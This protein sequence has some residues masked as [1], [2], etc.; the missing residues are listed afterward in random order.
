[1]LQSRVEDATIEIYDLNG[2]KLI[3]K[4]IPTGRDNMKLM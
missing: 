1:M 4:K 3:E 2:R